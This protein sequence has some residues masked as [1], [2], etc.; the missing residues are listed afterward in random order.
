MCSRNSCHPLTH[1]HPPTCFGHCSL[2]AVETK[3]L[4]RKIPIQN[5]GWVVRFQ[6]YVGL[7]YQHRDL[8]VT[9]LGW[10]T[11]HPHTTIYGLASI[12]IYM[13]AFHSHTHTCTACTSR[14]GSPAIAWKSSVN[15][16]VRTL[17][18]CTLHKFGVCTHINCLSAAVLHIHCCAVYMFMCTPVHTPLLFNVTPSRAVHWDC[19]SNQNRRDCVANIIR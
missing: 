18:H 19:Q 17:C 8:S 2:V 5:M 16:N 13:K 4:K 10:L 3:K 7:V 9:V 14:K 1:T 11:T 6:I 15:A 12:W